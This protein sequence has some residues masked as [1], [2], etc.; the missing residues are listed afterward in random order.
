MLSRKSKF[1]IAIHTDKYC[2]GCKHR[3]NAL[4][5]DDDNGIIE[6]K[7]KLV[8]S[9]GTPNVTDDHHHVTECDKYESN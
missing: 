4:T 7:C 8:E 6:F 2:A 9:G 3:M 5:I 1:W